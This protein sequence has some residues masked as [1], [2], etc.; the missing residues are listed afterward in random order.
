MQVVV[1]SRVMLLLGSGGGV[2]GPDVGK[3]NSTY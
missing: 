2:I 1:S 3:K